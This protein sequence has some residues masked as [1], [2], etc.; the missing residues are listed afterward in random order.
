MFLPGYVAIA[1]NF[2]YVTAQ[3]ELAVRPLGI[4]HYCSL[5]LMSNHFSCPSYFT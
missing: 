5:S 1:N 3:F 2:M 4:N